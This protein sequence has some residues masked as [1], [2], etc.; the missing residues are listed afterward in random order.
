MRR[1]AG[2]SFALCLAG[3][4]NLPAGGPLRHDIERGA[5][6]TLAL[7]RRA[8][9]KEYALV[10]VSDA[11][12]RELPHVNPGSFYDSFG[13]QKNISSAFRLGYG[14]VLQVTIF[15]SASG[16]LFAPSDSSLR[17]GNFVSLPTQTISRAGTI[18]VPYAGEVRA[19]GR[20]VSEVQ[21]DIERRL[22]SRAVEP[23]VLITV[24]EQ[25]TSTVT[26]IGETASKQQLRGDE[27]ILDMIARSGG[28]RTPTHEL[29][30]TLIR[31]GK[32]ATVYFPTLV[33]EPKENILVA[34]GDTIHVYKEQQRFVAVG[35]FGASGVT[36][37]VT[38]L[39]PFDDEKLSLNE[40]VAKAGG[41]I[42]TR[43]SA[44]VFVY[45][46]ESRK[47]LERM[48]VDVSPFNERELVPTIYRAN[49]R[50]PSVYF[51]AQQFPMRH[52]DAIYVTTSDSVEL[53][54]FMSHTLAITGTISGVT[55]DIAATR[56]NIRSLGR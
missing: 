39:F 34:P 37:G 13:P 56:E 31:K 23:Q 17:P 43:S 26:L 12:L 22:A 38:G 20:V 45:R 52:R 30:V 46:M 15:E 48:G 49:F 50:D 21:K 32:R 19:A 28:S 3:C 41:L 6:S 44:Q 36:S 25:V 11:V 27:R 54:K 18:T 1:F 29:F 40:A 42:D 51:F 24:G 7:D 55:G 35:S 9:V 53:E 4:T 5:L 8:V 10:D 33:R 47:V 2:I 14:D 16:G